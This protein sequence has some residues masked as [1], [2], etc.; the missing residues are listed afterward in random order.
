MPSDKERPGS[1]LSKRM[2]MSPG[3]G[4]GPAPRSCTHSFSHKAPWG[5]SEDDRE[6]ERDLGAAVGFDPRLLLVE[7]RGVHEQDA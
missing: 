1:P 4:E 6:R 7:C 5:T 2:A 3:R